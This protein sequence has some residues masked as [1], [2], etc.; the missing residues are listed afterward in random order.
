MDQCV[1]NLHAGKPNIHTLHRESYRV[2]IMNFMRG[3]AEETLRFGTQI[4]HF[5]TKPFDE[6]LFQ[7]QRMFLALCS[8]CSGGQGYLFL[9]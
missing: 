8:L 1:N 7:H 2:V 3:R 6:S 5:Q 9:Q 4:A